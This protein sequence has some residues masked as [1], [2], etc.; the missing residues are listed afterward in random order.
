MKGKTHAFSLASFNR[1][2]VSKIGVRT[3]HHW[4]TA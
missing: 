2:D 3:L 1:L 4:T